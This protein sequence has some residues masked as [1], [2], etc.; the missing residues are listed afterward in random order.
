MRKPRCLE[1]AYSPDPAEV[2]PFDFELL[3]TLRKD[4][5]FRRRNARHTHLLI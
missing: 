1:F 2:W 4:E 3:W 5:L